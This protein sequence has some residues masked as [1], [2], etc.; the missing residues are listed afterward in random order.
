[1][2]TTVH[3]ILEEKGTNLWSVSPQTKL[4][5]A[6]KLMTDQNIGAL[7]VLEGD[8][9]IG[10]ISERDFVRKIVQKEDCPLQNPV[11]EMMTPNVFTVAPSDSIEQCMKMMTI[12]RIRHLPVIEDNKPVGMISIGDVIKA[13]L[14]SRE[15]T[16]EQMEKYITGTP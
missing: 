7:L 2:L 3:N 8:A 12:K 10:I 14:N 15:F 11:S 13:I 4:I 5:D 16:I 9:V 6:L 1:L